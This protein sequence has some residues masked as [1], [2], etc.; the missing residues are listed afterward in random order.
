MSAVL[1]G[2]RWVRDVYEIAGDVPA[3]VAL[4]ELAGTSATWVV[5]RLGVHRW[6]LRRRDVLHLL[7]TDEVLGGGGWRSLKVQKAL[8]L[9]VEATSTT[10]P[11]PTDLTRPSA[12]SMAF[13]YPPARRY[14]HVGAQ[15]EALGVAEVSPQA[16]ARAGLLERPHTKGRGTVRKSARPPGEMAAPPAAS[17][18]GDF[19]PITGA[20]P[21]EPQSAGPPPDEPQAAG[22]SPGE[23]APP[24]PA[25]R[26]TTGD[27]PPLPSPRPRGI[28]ATPRGVPTTGPAAGT[29]PTVS[30]TTD[31]DE[32]TTPQRFPSL[33]ANTPPVRG[34]NITI[35]VDLVR[36]QTTH[37]E[38]GALEVG[39]LSADWTTLIVDVRL[40][41]S[42]ITFDGGAQGQVTIRRN[43]DSIA[44]TVTGTVTRDGP[45]D[46]AASFMCGSRFVGMATRR[47]EAG[48][49][50]VPTAVTAGAV[51]VDVHAAQPDVTVE[52]YVEDQ[53]Q[54][55]KLHWVVRPRELFDGLPPQLDGYTN[56]GTGVA[57][58]A[59]SMFARFA[60]LERGQH[61]GKIESHGDELWRKA[62]ACWQDGYW[63]LVD[64][65]QRPLTIQFVT[66]EPSIA[67]ELMRPSRRSGSRTETHKPL[68]LEHSV[69]RWV[70]ALKGMMRNRLPKGRLYTIVPRY[71]SV[72]RALKR[73]EAEGEK[74]K[75][76]YAA[77]VVEGKYQ[78]VLSLLKAGEVTEP[79][80]L[81]HFAGHGKFDV[82]AVTESA[83]LLE[84]GEV[85]V[86]ELA[87]PD[88][89]LGEK[90]RPL[91]FFNACEVGATGQV[92]GAVGGWGR[93][94]IERSFSGF[95]A[96]LWA[97]D[98]ADAGTVA[99]ELVKGILIDHS[100]PVSTVLREI[101]RTHG[102]T[103]PTFY[104]YV[105]F[106]DV[107][108][109]I[110]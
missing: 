22:P 34:Q 69:A 47:F 6:V 80:A 4:T 68:A 24:A 39:Q 20:A 102:A 10:T 48:S 95:I 40:M 96:P 67:W 98:D 12:G 53:S 70:A 60:Q 1:R 92:L 78:S 9:S 94:C 16:L 2:L 28:P 57:E 64:H 27:A 88:V 3:L 83:I 108:A 59:G 81:L 84:D 43:Q 41:S 73:A 5:V 93:A 31:D 74:L 85:T 18:P 51:S 42:G 90:Y 56:L 23:M 79:I 50:L 25:M 66:D 46:V 30:P 99:A 63:A 82:G 101:R 11:S 14:V 91:V 33:D 87:S 13:A 54:P 71:K 19:E 8:N 7:D 107:T 15:G 21:D 35:T 97:V 45:I 61:A 109:R 26:G 72:S 44:A 103:S 32:G 62:P 75:N 77:Q 36:R 49:A 89:H 37:T 110:A 55:G 104:S 52:I 76:E 105:F 100:Q 17:E 106:G 29:E 38:G 65:Y 86:S 58:F